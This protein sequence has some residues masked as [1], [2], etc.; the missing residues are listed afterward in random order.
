[1]GLYIKAEKGL[2]YYRNKK[3]F[4]MHVTSKGL[5]FVMHDDLRALELIYSTPAS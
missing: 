5:V 2:L 4:V 1:M 3:V